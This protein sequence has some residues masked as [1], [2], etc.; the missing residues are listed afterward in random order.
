MLIT[1]LNEPELFFH[2]VKWFQVLLHNSHNLTSV[3]YLHT[4]FV[5][6][7]PY[8]RP[9]QVLPF[10]VRVNQGTM[11]STY[12]PNHQGWNFAI[13]GFNVISTILVRG[14]TTMYRC[15]P[16]R[17][18]CQSRCTHWISIKSGRHLTYLYGHID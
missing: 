2:T 9:Y 7:D 12:S 8:I 3:I 16:H 15:C 17:R 10:R 4:Y 13:K 14:L 6:V 18:G 1:F 5:P 11:G